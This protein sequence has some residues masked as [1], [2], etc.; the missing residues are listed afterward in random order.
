VTVLAVDLGGSHIGCA[1]VNGG[2]VLAASS[3][4]VQGVSLSLAL[5]RIEVTLRQQCRTLG[6]SPENCRG[7]GFGIPAIVDSRTTEILSVL[8]KFEDVRGADLLAWSRR[9]FGLPARLQNDAA[10]ALLGECEQGA[11]RG[12]GDVVMVTLGTGIGVAVMLQGK[13]MTSRLGQAGCLGG[14]L[15]VRF[16][17]RPCI[18]GNLGCA[19]AEASTAA[20]PGLCAGWP[21]FAGSLLAREPV[22]DFAALFRAKDAGDRVAQEVFDHCIDVWSALAVTLVHAYGP[23]RMIFGGGVLRR[24]EEILPAI[25]T[26]VHEHTWKTTRGA[27]SI[28]PASLGEAA[29]FLGAEALFG[30]E[31]T[32]EMR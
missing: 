1:V 5:P 23:Q 17:G 15:T 11:G 22:C 32:Q 24:A 26:F 27:V 19:E 6:I 29:A 21:G 18:C 28:E 9:A 14:H 20:L 7:I 10:L 3:L 8:N 2:S 16:N 12:F 13:I 31:F 4:P 30:D 25:R